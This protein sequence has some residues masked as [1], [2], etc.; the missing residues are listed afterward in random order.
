MAMQAKKPTVGRRITWTSTWDQVESL[1]VHE[2]MYVECNTN[3]EALRLQHTAQARRS[4]GLLSREI[5]MVTRGD[6]TYFIRTKTI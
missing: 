4:R 2:V 3:Q 5:S 1:E 6:T